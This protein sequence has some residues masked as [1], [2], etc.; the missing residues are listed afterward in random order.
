MELKIM[1]QKNSALS[2]KDITAE[3]TFEN[4]T[5]SRQQLKQSIATKAK[6]KPELL[7]VKNVYNDYGQRKAIVHAH[8]Y[9]DEESMKA[10][11]YPKMLEKNAVK[12]EPKKEEAPEKKQEAPS[13][14]KKEE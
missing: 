9:E 5:P 14:E 4:T 8:L 6:A 2:R 13:E 10:I 1:E 12:E 11:E 7:I 3:V